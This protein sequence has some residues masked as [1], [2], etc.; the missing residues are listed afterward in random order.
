MQVALDAIEEKQGGFCVVMDGKVTA[1]VPLPVAGLFS[2]KRVHQVA[3][4]VKALKLEWEKAG[5]TRPLSVIRISGMTDSG[6]R[7]KTI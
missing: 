6:I 5:C 4:E 7:L 1:M 3:D 2:D